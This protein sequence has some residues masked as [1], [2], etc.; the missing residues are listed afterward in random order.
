METFEQYLKENYS[1]EELKI[2]ATH[3][4]E[5]GVNGMIWYEET[6]DIYNRFEDELHEFINDY[7]QDFGTFPEYIIKNFESPQTFRNSVVW[8]CAEYVAYNLTSKEEA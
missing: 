6:T 8:F 5:G 2:M 3:G 4:C 1:T 7:V